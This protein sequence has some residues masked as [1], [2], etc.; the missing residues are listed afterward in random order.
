MK[1]DFVG[2][3]FSVLNGLVFLLFMNRDNIRV[4]QYSGSILWKGID[5][6]NAIFHWL[7]RYNQVLAFT[8]SL[9]YAKQAF[10]D[11]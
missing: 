9:F 10:C 6:S 3:F 7:L 11:S 4:C 2:E 1:L 8:Q 5:W